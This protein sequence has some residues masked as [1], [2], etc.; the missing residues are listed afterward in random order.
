M[1]ARAKRFGGLIAAFAVAFV[2]GGIW[3]FLNGGFGPR[4]TVHAGKGVAIEIEELSFYNSRSEKITGKVY[5]PASDTTR[6]FPVLV[7]CPGLGTSAKVYESYY[8]D[9]ASSGMVLYAF[10]FRGGA[11]DGKSTSLTMKE[12]TLGTEMD[13]L[14]TVLKAIRDVRYVDRHRVFVLGA[15]QGALVAALVAARHKELMRALILLYPAFNIPDRVRELY[16]RARDIPDSAEFAGNML[17]KAYFKEAHSL[18]PYKK[19]RKFDKEVLIL[20]GSADNLVLPSVSS[21][22][23]SIYRNSE[24]VMIEGSG[25]GFS[26]KDRKLATETIISFISDNL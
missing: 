11:P 2:G 4:Q 15:S 23:D 21:K 20:H 22:A 18:N 1:G 19:I 3:Y 7:F 24:L 9:F 6:H 5:R 17:G 14:E 10:D 8:K 25:H 12:M 26:G 13:D 16:P